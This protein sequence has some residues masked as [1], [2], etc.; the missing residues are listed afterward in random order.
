VRFFLRMTALW[1]LTAYLGETVVAPV[2]SI[3]GIAPDFA[4]IAV[5][6]LALAA[7]TAPATVGG[8]LTGLAQD[9]SNPTV[10]GLRALCKTCLGY[11][12]GKLRGRLVHGMPLVEAAVV[13]VAVL[14]HDVVF[15]L[16]QSNL[17]DE[18]FLL[19]LVTKS[20]PVAVYSAVVAVPLLRLAELLGVLAPED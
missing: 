7:G 11:G 14:A 2:I 16:V 18:A 3:A 6:M 15:L 1:V 13:A 9:L 17:V 19:P 12:L 10:L 8:F 5:V 20:L 4:M